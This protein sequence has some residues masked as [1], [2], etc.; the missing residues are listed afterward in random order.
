MNLK[1]LNCL[2]FLFATTFLAVTTTFAQKVIKVDSPEYHKAKA[3]GTLDQYSIALDL[4]N[5]IVTGKAKPA[6]NNTPKSSR[7]TDCDCYVQPDAT[8]TLA[9][10]PND[11]GSSGV[12]NLP[13]SFNFY[14][15]NYTS[16]YINNNGNVTFGS[17]LSTYSSTAFPSNNN[18]IIAPFWGDVDTRGGNG[19]VLYKITP[20]AIFVNWEAVGYYNTQGDKLNTFQLILTD[21]TDP[22]IPD[23]KNIAFCYQDMQWTTGSAS[24]GVNGFGG[25]PAT[26]GANKG[27]NVGYFLIG[28]FDHAGIDFDGPLG[29]NDGISYL[30][31]KSYFFDISNANNIPPIAQGVS[32]C[33]TFKICTYGDTAHF[34]IT[35]LSPELNQTTSITYNDGGLTTLTEESNVS[36]N[37]AS[38]VLS[39]VGTA[40]AAGV[41]T[42]VVTATDDYSPTPGITNLTFYIEIVDANIVL[43]PQLSFTTACDQFP[44]SVLNGPY[45]G[46]LWDDLSTQPTSTVTQ[47]GTYGVTVNKNGCYKRV[48]ADIF[49]PEPAAFN[50]QGNL[51]LCP[52]E[53][54]TEISIGQP[55]AI[56]VMN[57][58]TGNPAVD[59]GD[60]IIL[61]PGTY[62]IY[63]SDTTGLC[64]NDTTFTIS[65]GVAS[66]IFNDAVSCNNLTYQVTGSSVGTSCSWS[67]PNPEISFSNPTA[68]NPTITASTYGIYTINLSNPCG[69]ELEAELIFTFPPTIFADDTICGDTYDVDIATVNSFNGGVWSTVAPQDITFSDPNIPNPTIHVNTIPYSAQVTY[70]DKYCPTLKDQAVIL[71]VPSGFPTV[72]QTA[73]NLGTNGLSVSSF[74]GGTWSVVD[75]P[76]TAWAEDTASHFNP[77]NNS[78]NPLLT[79]STPGDYHI[80]YYDNF[81][82][83]TYDATINFPGYIYTEVKD[84]NLCFGITYELGALEPSTPVTYMWNTGATTP[85]IMVSE[86]GMYYVT[87]SNNCYTYTDSALISYH[88]CDIQ[89]PNVISLSSQA[90]NN[91]WFVDADGIAEF[92]CVI[93]NRW[94]NIIYEYSDLNGNWDGKDRSGHIVPEGVYFYT[95]KAKIYGGDKLEKHGF[96]EVVH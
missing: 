79:V 40:A 6:I 86:S 23:G 55:T 7:S 24:S 31:Y 96:I 32:S 54:S 80:Q 27:D 48:E 92:N 34:M 87:I 82:D 63:N 56:Q 4:K 26:A 8:Y 74:Q 29:N 64:N 50:L 49:V 17:G 43:D 41:Y 76:A 65:Q 59:S 21:G 44:I 53:T 62:H 88:L 39:A 84:T 37:V 15:T 85:S 1:K 5:E 73:C 66:T 91:I 51:F 9:L 68:N 12:I 45:D 72:P 20:H 83:V 11:D 2:L 95:I 57:W 25:V 71:F 81:C 3:N 22:S 36:G 35:F 89:A 16:L 42:I 14:G 78:A 47:T 10:A 75:N 18:K 19:Q 61:G 67:S 60:T 90:G 30:D 93:V 13:F 46:Y 28:R 69:N 94:G 70:T 33:D 58:N 52:G 77:N 38:I